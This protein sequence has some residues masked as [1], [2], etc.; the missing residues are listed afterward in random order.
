VTDPKKINI[1]MQPSITDIS[2]TGKV[3]VSF[4]KDV[5]VPSNYENITQDAIEITLITKKEVKGRMLVPLLS[6]MAV[7]NNFTWNIT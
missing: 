6:E 1:E 7:L 5:L 3:T 2:S 4:N